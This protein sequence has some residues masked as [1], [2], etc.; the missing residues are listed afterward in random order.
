VG[1]EFCQNLVPAAADFDAA[2]ARFPGR[3][4]LVT[5][6]L[7]DEVFDE[8]ERIVARRGARR[9][10][11]EVV[12]NDLGLLHHLRRRHAARVSV[13]VGRV[14]GHRVKVMPAGFARELLRAHA[15]RRVEVDDAALPR[16]F[17]GFPGLR[18]SFHA[19]FLYRSV[20]RF[21]PWERHWPQPCSFSCVGC[22]R[23]LRHPHLPQ[24][25]LLKGAAYGV[26]TRGV[27][28]HPLIDRL[29]L[30]RLPRRGDA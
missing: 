14:L 10:R 28:E 9:G 6:L 29:V 15:V 18:L 17:E 16:R 8:V 19:P 3:V 27:P 11:L 12:V 2:V 7:G 22:L 20:T 5:P 13:S 30:E 21:C 26:R 4:V 23:I 25:L 1:D 24:P